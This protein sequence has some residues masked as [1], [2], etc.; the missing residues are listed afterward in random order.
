FGPLG[1]SSPSALTHSTRALD[2]VKLAITLDSATPEIKS[3]ALS[4]LA[5]NAQGTRWLLDTH[6][7]G[8][9]PKELVEQA[10]RLLRNSPFQGERNRAL[11]LFPAPGKLNPKNLPAISELAKRTGDAARGKA[12]WNASFAGAAQCSKCHMVRGVG[13]QVGPDLAMIGK[14]GSRENILESILQPSKA[15]AD[16]YVQHAVTTTAEVTV[17]GLLVADTPEAITLRDANGKDTTIAKK[18]VAGEVRK[19]KIS[20]MPEDVVAALT[21]DELADLV[22][23]LET[24]KVAAYTPDAFHVTGPFPA[25]SMDAALDKEYGPEKAA[26]DAGAKFGQLTWKTIRPDGKGYFDLAAMHGSAANNSASYLYA[27]VDSPAGQDAE[28]LLG[29]DDG[30]RLW[31]NGKEVFTSRE[32]RAATPEQ[33]KVAVKLAKGKNAILLKVANGNNPHGVYFSLASAE[34]VKPAAGK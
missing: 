7:K 21:E 14:K 9:L 4:A 23:Y 26:F 3:A 29:P 22:A 30:A 33:H 18:D 20:I 24:L 8:E 19:L 25:E 11:T 16:Q 6:Q 31:V 32:T 1:R 12:V 5:G 28:V 10:G 13:G 2:S 27:E 34:E 17:S 15:I